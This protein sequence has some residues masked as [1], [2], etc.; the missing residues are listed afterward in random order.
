MLHGRRGR[1]H[2]AAPQRFA[3]DGFEDEVGLLLA[4]RRLALEVGSDRRIRLHRFDAAERTGLGLV[5][6]AAEDD[7]AVGGL[8]MEVEM[9]IRSLL[10]LELR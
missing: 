1:I 4:A 5:L 8:Q 2:L 10:N 7:L 3:V 6:L 9:T